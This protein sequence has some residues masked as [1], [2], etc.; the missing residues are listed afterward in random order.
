MTNTLYRAT[1]HPNVDSLHGLFHFYQ[2]IG[3]DPAM[4]SPR[5]SRWADSRLIGSTVRCWLNLNSQDRPPTCRSTPVPT[6][7]RDF[8]PM[9]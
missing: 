7:S 9:D 4:G 3:S 8:V 1:F 2:A 5:C 6:W